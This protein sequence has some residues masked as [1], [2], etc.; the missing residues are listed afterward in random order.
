MLLH[1]MVWRQAGPVPSVHLFEKC[2]Q[3]GSERRALNCERLARAAACELI[4]LCGHRTEV[5]R[6]CGALPHST[7]ALGHGDR[8]GGD[9]RYRRE[10]LMWRNFE[11]RV[12]LGWGGQF[13][14]S[15]QCLPLIGRS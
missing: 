2:S 9:R 5:K 11:C 7:S 8:I 4:D 6:S 14:Y 3:V 1:K 15:V 10:S 12:I 13:R